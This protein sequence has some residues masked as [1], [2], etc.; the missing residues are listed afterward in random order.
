MLK[1]IDNGIKPLI[2]NF[3]ISQKKV[4]LLFL[5]IHISVTQTS[6]NSYEKIKD[7]LYGWKKEKILNTL[8]KFSYEA[9]S[10]GRNN[11]YKIEKIQFD[12]EKNLYMGKYVKL[13]HSSKTWNDVE[14]RTIEKHQIDADNFIH[15]FIDFNSF[16][17]GFEDKS[18]IKNL[19]T[20]FN[21]F[22]NKFSHEFN[23]KCDFIKDEVELLE[24]I[25]NKNI[26]NCKFNVQ[27]TNPSPFGD[28]KKAEGMLD[29]LL[30]ERIRLESKTNFNKGES[31]L[32]FTEGSLLRSFV[33]LSN[34]GYG[35]FEIKYQVDGN[36]R[37]NKIYNSEKNLHQEFCSDLEDTDKNTLFRKG[38]YLLILEK[39]GER[40]SFKNE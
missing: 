9:K 21:N 24:I 40:K 39:L 33:S 20:A 1:K 36:S 23:Y 8:E 29:E 30:A 37:T 28:A 27:R 35:R 19:P 2:K 38:E 22:F 13:K 4:K 25:N 18:I 11:S 12:S 31:G 26:I 32:N 15:F 10:D 6:I 5:R 7:D 3:D 34:E 17:L 16:I 14:N